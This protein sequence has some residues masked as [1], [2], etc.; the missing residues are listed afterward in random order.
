M[1]FYW[2][3]SA[4]TEKE[5]REEADYCLDLIREYPLDYPVFL[6]TEQGS[7]SGLNSLSKAKRT[8]CIQA[9][10]DRIREA[11]YE[12]GIYAS[13]SWFLANLDYS[14]LA[15]ERIWVASWNGRPSYP[16]QYTAWQYTP[17]GIIPGI[18]QNTTDLSYWF[19]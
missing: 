15:G 17:K 8:A 2:F 4:L 1:G 12:V 16:A 18:T 10:L 9:F 3:T 7:R 13:S 14:K 11:G 6:D 19:E 5:A